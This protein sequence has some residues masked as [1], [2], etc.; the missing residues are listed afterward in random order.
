M[1]AYAGL[2][3]CFAPS[4]H[5]GDTCEHRREREPQQILPKRDW[6]GDLV[7]RREIAHFI[8]GLT[9]GP[10]QS[11]GRRRPSTHRPACHRA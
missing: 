5:L 6:A 1:P 7:G 3:V 8:R 9:A 4:E 10:T 2:R 11:V